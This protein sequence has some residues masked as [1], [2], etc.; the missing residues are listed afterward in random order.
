MQKLNKNYN[1]IRLLKLVCLIFVVILLL[2]SIVIFIKKKIISTEYQ[3]VSSYKEENSTSNKNNS[4]TNEDM[5]DKD[6]IK[7]GHYKVGDNMPAGEYKIFPENDYAYFEITKDTTGKSTSIIY[8][9]IPKDFFYLSANKG[10]YVK[11]QDC[12]AIPIK[13]AKK[14]N[15]NVIKNGQYKV[16]FD[17]PAGEYNLIPDGQNPYFEVNSTPNDY[18]QI[19]VSDIV[20]KNRLV[21]VKNGQYLKIIDATAS[22]K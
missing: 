17:I 12:Y 10:Q 8:S 4:S 13:K 14:F 2:A 18:T 22:I 20:D 21:T 7:A 16:G 19:I 11:L 5:L 1:N 6:T 9:D 15:G 3:N